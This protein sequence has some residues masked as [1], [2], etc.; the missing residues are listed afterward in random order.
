MC[1]HRGGSGVLSGRG[2]VSGKSA[3]VRPIFIRAQD[4]LVSLPILPTPRVNSF[5]SSS[6]ELA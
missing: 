2:E 5:S 3:Y 1:E 4:H 6:S